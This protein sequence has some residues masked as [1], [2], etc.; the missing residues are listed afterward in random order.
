MMAMEA[1]Q[2]TSIG[3]KETERIKGS[4]EIESTE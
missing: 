4:K 3:Q 2:I 1:G